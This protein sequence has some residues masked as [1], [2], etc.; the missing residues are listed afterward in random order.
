MELPDK[1]NPVAAPRVVKAPVVP[2][3]G[4]KET[5][6]PVGRRFLD[7]V[8]AESPKKVMLGVI[9]QTLVPQLKAASEQAVNGFIHGML[10]N[11]GSSPMSNGMMRGTVLRGN[12]VVVNTQ[13]Y[14]ALSNPA[15]L[16]AAAVAGTMTGPYKDLTLQT[17]AHAEALLASILS[18]LNQYRVVTVSD[19]YEYA[20]L[21][22]SDSHAN[23]GW[24]SLEGSRI[25][26]DGSGYTL[27]LPKPVRV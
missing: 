25:V 26:Q 13:D 3:G 8:F 2:K 12:G 18:D 17:Q 6:R 22:P 14:N 7:Y 20:S 11:N 5:K 21:T 27:M 1:S 24:Y 10:W 9:Q 23:Y 19:L 16:Q 15:V 4:A